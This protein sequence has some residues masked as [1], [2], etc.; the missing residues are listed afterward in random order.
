[1]DYLQIPPRFFS[2]LPPELSLKMYLE[3]IPDFFPMI[4][5]I[6]S[7]CI[8]LENSQGI[9]LDHLLQFLNKLLHPAI[10]SVDLTEIFPE[11]PPDVFLGNSSRNYYT[12]SSISFLNFLQ[13]FIKKS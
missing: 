12:K 1:M 13:N 9:P 4:L 5:I 11:V 3:I 2:K 7:P 10:L 6:V 8:D